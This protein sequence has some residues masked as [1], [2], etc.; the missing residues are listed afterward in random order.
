LPSG[1]PRYEGCIHGPHEDKKK[2]SGCESISVTNE[3]AQSRK[4][5]HRQNDPRRVEQD[6]VAIWYLAAEN[7]V[8]CRRK[9]DAVIILPRVEPQ[10]RVPEKRP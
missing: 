5:S 1:N 9:I 7:K 6:E 4:R 3:V 10:S 2:P 8:L